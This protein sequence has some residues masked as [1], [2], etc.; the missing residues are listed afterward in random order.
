MK[1]FKEAMKNLYQSLFEE[2]FG[3]SSVYDYFTTLFGYKKIAILWCIGCLTSLSGFIESYIWQTP[4]AIYTLV[5]AVIIDFITGVWGAKKKGIKISSRK[6]P[7]FLVTLFSYMTMLSLSFNMAHESQTLG[8]LPGFLYTGFCGVTLYSIWENFTK[9]GV[10]D[11]NLNT[12][13][14]NKLKSL[15]SQ[16]KNNDEQH[17]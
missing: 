6:L 15:Y 14:K 11:E 7:R 1:N 17:N 5:I 8:F 10:F 4:S 3:F 12:Y 16:E 13:I 2:Y 9:I